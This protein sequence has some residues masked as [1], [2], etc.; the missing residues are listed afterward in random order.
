MRIIRTDG[1][2]RVANATGEVEYN[3]EGKPVRMFGMFQDIT[4]RK[5]AEEEL[6]RMMDQVVLVNEKL[7]VVG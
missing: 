3:A 5:K 1:A 4:E 6:N 7:N 2:L